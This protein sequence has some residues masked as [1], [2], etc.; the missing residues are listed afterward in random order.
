MHTSLLFYIQD[1]QDTQKKTLFLIGDTRY[2]FANFDD[3]L[4]YFSFS[5]FS[6]SRKVWLT[7][8]I[9]GDPPQSCHAREALDVLS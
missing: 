1:T 3:L 2:L 5:F 7:H 9:A 4:P 6:I 8:R